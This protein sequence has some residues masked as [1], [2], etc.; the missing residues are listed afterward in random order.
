MFEGITWAMVGNVALWVVVGL[1]L[2]TFVPYFVAAY[3]LIKETNRWVLPA[4]EPKYVLPP[5]AT[6][7]LYVLA[8]LTI[9]GT[10]NALA[11]MHPALLIAAVYS[12][13]D[14]VRQTIKIA[15]R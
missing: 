13:Q 3:E 2:R 14:I 15:W 4:F 1:L 9:P 10:L 11:G 7:G 6:L 5:A 8:A 12:G